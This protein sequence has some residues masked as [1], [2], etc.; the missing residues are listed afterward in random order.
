MAR[1]FAVLTTLALLM[2]GSTAHAQIASPLGFCKLGED[3]HTTKVSGVVSADTIHFGFP[4]KD[5]YALSK[6]E[7]WED[8]NEPCKTKATFGRFPDAVTLTDSISETSNTCSGSVSDEIDVGA[9][10]HTPHGVFVG[11]IAV[12][13]NTKPDAD[14]RRLKGISVMPRT[15]TEDCDVIADVTDGEG[16]PIETSPEYELHT[17]TWDEE[18]KRA[19]AEDLYDRRYCKAGQVATGLILHRSSKGIAGAQLECRDVIRN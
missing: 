15:V 9:T 6:I 5:Y 12:W 2:T 3:V 14:N 1:I 19:N 7:N 18:D 13:T 10:S 17:I 16:Y 8:D 4:G 11:S